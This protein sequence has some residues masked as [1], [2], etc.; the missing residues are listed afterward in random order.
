MYQLNQIPSQAQSRK[1]FRRILFGKNVFCPVCNSKKVDKDRERYW[2]PKCRRRFTLLSHTWLRG[3]KLSYQKLYLILWCWLSALPVKQAEKLTKLS[4]EAVRHWYSLFRAQLP[5]TPLILEKKVQMDEAYG[6]GWA[7]LL[8]KQIG[9]RKLAYTFLPQKSVQKH[10]AISFVSQYVS[11]GSRLNTDG[12]KIYRKIEQWW[13]VRHGVD[14][15]CKFQFGKTS[16][17]EGMFGV[18]RT[19]LRRMYHHVRTENM[20]EYVREFCARFSSPEMFENPRIYLTKTLR[21]APL[22]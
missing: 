2:C 12:A 19:F 14:L 7:L 4:E 6:H 8:A 5:E 11:P 16:E 15:H 3:T 20:P 22:D 9:S 18:F 13:P 21:S 10:E 1:L 17:I